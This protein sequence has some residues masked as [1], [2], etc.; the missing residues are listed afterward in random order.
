VSAGPAIAASHLSKKLCRD[1]RRAQWYGVRDIVREIV[2]GARAR[3]SG[4]L[5]PGEFWALHDLSFEVRPGESLAVVG[6]NGAGKST[7]LKVLYGLVKPDGGQVRMAGRVGALIEL[8]TGFDATLSGRENV[9]VNAALH[10][11]SRRETAALM[12]EIADFAEL[13]DV[14]DV[15]LQHYSSGMQARLSYAVAAHLKPDVLLVDEVLAVGDIRYQR[16]CIQHMQ[17]YLDAGGALV[18]VSHSTHQIQAIC[19]S[20]IVL[21]RGRLAFAGTAVEAV[22]TYLEGQQS[23]P[24]AGGGAPVPDDGHPVAIE[25]VEVRAVNGGEIG[26]GEG[27]RLALRYHAREPVNAI[28]VFSIWT[29]DLWVCVT[30]FAHERPRTLAAG[31]GELSCVVPRLPLVPG[32][33]MLKC[34][35]LDADLGVPLALHGWIDPPHPLRVRGDLT[36]FNNAAVTSQQLVTID[37]DWD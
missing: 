35:L 7:L 3:A 32:L 31:S 26:T 1:L 24:R 34:A 8:G 18:F 19:R 15:P 12:D 29:H 4:E 6:A 30:S 21:E 14:M 16:K 36:R 10:G 25:G 5:R 23:A 9:H 20:G 13:H 28:C 17:K 37:A 22:G 27:V 11:F 2:P 33:Y